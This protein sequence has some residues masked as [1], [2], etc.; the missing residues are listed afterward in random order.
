MFSGT[1]NDKSSLIGDQFISM[2]FL[3]LNSI[4]NSSGS[5][6]DLIFSDKKNISVEV[7][8][9]S[10]V[11]CDS[12]H[13][14]LSFNYQVPVP[15]IMLDD[16]HSFR[17]FNNADF[18]S[19]AT[20]LADNDW[21][22]TFN[23]QPAD[24]SATR[25]QESIL[26]AIQRFVP[27][28]SFRSST[29]PSW[30]SPVLKSLL[31]KKKS[32]HKKFKI[33]GS[34]HDY[35]LFSNLR[36]QCKALSKSCLKTHINVAQSRLASSPRDFWS[37][38]NKRR[39][40]SSIPNQV[41]LNDISANGPD[42]AQLFSSFFASTYKQPS[43]APN[44]ALMNIEIQQFSFLPSHLSISIEE[45]SVALK[46]LS[47]VRGVGP[48]DIPASLLFKC[49]EVLCSPLCTIFNK[50]LTEGFFPAVWKISRITPILKSGDPTLVTNYR[51]IS[52][53]PFIGKL[54]ELI[55]LKQIERSL[56]S[57][58]SMDQH[59]FFPGRSTITSSLD[60][61]CFIRDAF[62]D[63]SQVDAI[64]T[65][66]SK[67]FDSVD[68]NSLIYTL[69]KLGIGIP[70]LS[71]IRSY[72]V[73]RWQY[74]KLFNISSSKFKVSSGV[75]QGG[76]LSP[77]LF[78][79]FVNSIF[80]NVPSVRLL[81]FADDA[82]LFSRISS[83]TDC[84]VLQSSFNNFINWCQ[85]IGLT[86]NFDKYDSGTGISSLDP[87]Q[88][89]GLNSL[90]P[91][92]KILILSRG[93]FQPQKHE[94]VNLSYPQE[95]GHRF[96]AEH[97]N[98]VLPDGD[99]IQRKWLSF[100][101]SNGRLYC[102]YCMFFGKNVQKSWTIDGF[103]AWQRIKDIGSHEKTEG[104]INASIVVKLKLLAIPVLP[105]IYEHK[106]KQIAENRE[107][108]NT[109]I[110]ITLFLGKHSLPFRGHREN[111]EDR[112]RGNFKD[113]TV[114]IS[115]F[116]PSLA[117]YV[118]RLKSR[119]RSE[120]N[121]LFWQRQNQL[122]HSIATCLK[123][124]IQNEIKKSKYFSV[125]IDTTFD[126]SRREQLAFIIRYVCYNDHV[127]VPVIRE[128]LL[129][130]KES[131][132]TSGKHLFLIFQDICSENALD[133]KLFLVG[134]SY[135]GASNMKGEYEGL[136][137]LI[138]QENPSAIYTWC[139]AHR[140]NLVVVQ[141]CKSS[142]DA[143][144]TFG[145]LEDLY[146]FIS[147]SKKRVAFFENHQKKRNPQERVRRLKRVETTRWSSFSNALKTVLITFDD[148]I[149][150]L[151]NIK[152][153]EKS[154]FKVRCRAN[155]LV[156]FLL[157]ERFILTALIFT[158][159]FNILDPI[160]KTFQSPDID[161]L[162]AITSLQVVKKD[163]K[164]LR[165]DD[166]FNELYN[167][168]TNIITKSQY[169]FKMLATSR[170]KKKKKMPGE[171]ASDET[172]DDPVKR[173]KIKTY[174]CTLDEASTAIKNRFNSTS[175]GLLKDI[176]YF[177]INRLQ[178]IKNDPSSLPKDVF[179]VFCSIYNKHNIQFEVLRNEYT[180]FS[181]LFFQFDVAM[182]SNSGFLHKNIE[183]ENDDSAQDNESSNDEEESQFGDKNKV[184]NNLASILNIFQVCHTSGL[185]SIFPT[186]Y[187]AL[188]IACTLPVSSTS[189]ERIFSKL[190]ILKNR[191][192]TTISQDRLEDLMIMTCE[193]D[194]EIINEDV[195]NIF[196]NLSSTLSKNLI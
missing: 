40:S 129:S 123:T 121:F 116:S 122:I 104:H 23:I 109:L 11:P 25:L 63:N 114:L 68:H 103:H 21:S 134:Q 99:R 120:I 41:Y 186:L 188:K 27:L 94:L 31:F 52:N 80:S 105:Q 195:T 145:I 6:L 77:L 79:I 156:D 86:L 67:A 190:K 24:L 26:D 61:S 1:I 168:A 141:V 58:L 3:Q 9:V 178:K 148:I 100:S 51:P 126:A 189:P 150:T 12:Y 159:I 177:S 153:T 124:T 151:E 130:L 142:V 43:A 4:H 139:Y 110:E 113:L 55:V 47:N 149:Q 91:E 107:I 17:D 70:L 176:S 179:K 155:G 37:F 166:E 44:L 22:T 185:G 14:A 65:D 85:A 13:P 45:V 98:R 87:K 30:V 158:K 28:K 115:K 146:S 83:S 36:S 101:V 66:F 187:L 48:D 42:V 90:T 15:L 33:T 170:S 162:G 135:D 38:I 8:P 71:W 127:P 118:D 81:L 165:C 112:L 5:L 174:L 154:D 88:Y 95:H 192:R 2:D 137:A 78:N 140:L 72:L 29:F 175:Q 172:I 96:T 193:S 35:N 194:I 49:R 50:S 144:D 20:A 161:L 53:L 133:W 57:T 59:G 183:I 164:N 132:S 64:F 196:A 160:T 7:A 128:R 18:D 97:Y 143:V 117:I 152:K 191:L 62:R 32:A 60:F 125:S 119:G 102:L 84:D 182:N 169:E 74:V 75:P 163:L 181:K 147:S 34:F 171:N 56:H 93:P 54:F 46:T 69:D 108:V 76:H 106:R 167:E 138:K 39:D 89:V 180:Q 19:I 173:F 184:V 136:Q 16:S 82:K 10:L 131:S 157:T 111:W 92:E 73:D